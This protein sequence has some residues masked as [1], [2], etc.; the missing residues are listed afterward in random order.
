VANE[1]VATAKW[2]ELVGPADHRAIAVGS[3]RPFS[4]HTGYEPTKH[5]AREVCHFVREVW[6]GVYSVSFSAAIEPSERIGFRETP[7]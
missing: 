3:V 4:T 6:P 2:L 7:A 1:P 5:K